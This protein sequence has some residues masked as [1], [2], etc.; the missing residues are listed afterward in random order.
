MEFLIDVGAV[1]ASK[2]TGKEKVCVSITKFL[3]KKW[4]SRI[5]YPEIHYYFEDKNNSISIYTQ[6]SFSKALKTKWKIKP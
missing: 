5:R 1:I 3:K 6:S 2:R 4:S